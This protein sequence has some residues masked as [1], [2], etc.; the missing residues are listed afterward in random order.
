MLKQPQYQ[1]LPVEKQV[2]ILYVVTN[3]YLD[4]IPTA[5]V[6]DFETRFYSFL[7]LSA[8]G[9]CQALGGRSSP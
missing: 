2:A 1:P 3:G 7:E 5:R 6:R 4:D 9:A 8:R